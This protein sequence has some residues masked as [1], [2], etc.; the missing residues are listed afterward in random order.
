VEFLTN[1]AEEIIQIFFKYVVQLLRGWCEWILTF[2]R[3]GTAKL[4]KTRNFWGDKM[5]LNLAIPFATFVPLTPTTWLTAVKHESLS[6][7]QWN[8]DFYRKKLKFCENPG[9]CLNFS[10]LV[11]FFSIFVLE[12]YNWVEC[13]EKG[14]FFRRFDIKPFLWKRQKRHFWN[15]NYGGSWSFFTNF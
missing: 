1:L 6:F 13:V 15:I 11:L 9:K 3:L 14:C 12:R 10:G 2:W 4:M 7:F 8:K 5:I